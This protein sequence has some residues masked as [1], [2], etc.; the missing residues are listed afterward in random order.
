VAHGCWTVLRP[1]P[2]PLRRPPPRGRRT[3]LGSPPPSP[4][5]QGHPRTCCLAPR[6]FTATAGEPGFAGILQAV[7]SAAAPGKSPSEDN[8][9][10]ARRAPRTR[11][12]GVGAM[13][14]RPRGWEPDQEV[15]GHTGGR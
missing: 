13:M 9:P 1:R 7:S 4:R 12:D 8:G 11:R 2:H 6:P 3:P 14:D 10:A 5:L 15:R